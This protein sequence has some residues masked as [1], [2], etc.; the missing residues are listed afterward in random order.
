MKIRILF[1]FL[2][3]VVTVFAGDAVERK[4]FP[5]FWVVAS[6]KGQTPNDSAIFQFQVM[7]QELWPETVKKYALASCN[8]QPF[9]FVFDHTGT[10]THVVAPGKHRF[11]FYVAIIGYSSDSIRHG[12]Y[13]EIYSDSVS[14]EE[15][16]ITSVQL[17]FRP[18]DQE[19]MVDKPVLYFY[20]DQTI[21][22]S[23]TVKP[24]GQF[25][26]TYPSIENGWNGTANPDGTVRIN[27]R[28]YPYLFWEAKC[29]LVA[30]TT[31]LS[32]GFIVQ[33]NETV[34]FLEK[35]LSAMGLNER[36]Q[37]DFITYWGPKL[38]GNRVNFVHFLFNNSCNTIADL[39]ITPQPDNQ[40]RIYMIWSELTNDSIPSPTPQVIPNF[41]RNGFTVV[42]WG[43]SEISIDEIQLK[44]ANR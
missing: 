5:D 21:D 42:E 24:I 23:A 17:R 27:D 11:Q 41:K 38:S 22:F 25:T 32:E 30:A 37:T 13:Y 34:A 35:Q 20:S 7:N 19:M 36:E 18:A 28:S 3:T 4:S 39:T 43:G 31:D 29:P 16:M 1:I 8:S 15:G 2:L 40:F 6:Q 10:F 33:G 26:F 14:I 12:S 44:T 9:P